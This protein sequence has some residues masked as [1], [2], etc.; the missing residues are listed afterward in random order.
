M[1]VSQSFL[2]QKSEDDAAWQTRIAQ[3]GCFIVAEAALNDAVPWLAERWGGSLEQTRL[4]WGET[5][6]IHA[7][8]SPY[9]I[10]VHAANWAQVREHILTQDGWGLG[11]QLAWFM[12]AYSPLDQ[13]LEV[14]KHLRNWSLVISPA[15]EDAI[16]RISDWLVVSQLLSASSA[17]EACALYG[18]IARF[19]DISPTG[20]VQTLSLVTREPHAISDRLPRQLSDRQWQAIMA[21]SEHQVLERYMA[22]LR[23]H[24]PH[25]QDDDER[26]L[27]FTRQQTEQARLNGFNN[28]RDIVRWLALATELAPD[29]IL[30]PWAQ[31]IM[32]QPE[33][34][35]T[36]NRMDRLYQAAV[37]QLDK[38]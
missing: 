31:R 15:G 36:Q 23:S 13:L 27:V 29:F 11:M 16:F 35:G 2:D 3:G 14:M 37:G 1:S 21:P 38:A 24:H 5:G 26:L 6:R 20:T 34:I 28:D 22:H 33:N 18:P 7:A 32:V 25:W 17:Q 9:C 10:P 4:Y 8:V 12:Q 30:Q 19:C